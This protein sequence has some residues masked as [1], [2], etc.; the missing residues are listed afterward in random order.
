M[1]Y[2]VT[3]VRACNG[4]VGLAPFKTCLTFGAEDD[5]MEGLI[6]AC[7]KCGA[8]NRKNPL[9]SGDNPVC[10]KCGQPLPRGGGPLAL[11]EL[12]FEPVLRASPVPIIVDFW[13]DWCGPCKMFAPVLQQYAAKHQDD[14]LVAKVDTEANQSIAARFGIRSI[15]TVVLF[16][17]PI[18]IAR[19]SGALPAPALEQWVAQALASR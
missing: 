3:I 19:Q 12:T 15:P 8:K 7:S 10:G 9:R 1:K 14:L 13:A 17:G 4:V 5:S 18:E 11:D 16:R 2:Q 6:V